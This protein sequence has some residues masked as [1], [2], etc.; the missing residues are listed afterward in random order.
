MDPTTLAA[1]H[2]ELTKIAKEST[3]IGRLVNADVGKNQFPDAD[4]AKRGLSYPHTTTSSPNPETHSPEAAPAN[5]GFT[6]D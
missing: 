4:K 2:D 5:G 6:Y 1:F 3:E